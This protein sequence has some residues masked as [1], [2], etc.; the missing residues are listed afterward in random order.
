[1]EI[2]ARYQ[3]TDGTGGWPFLIAGL[4]IITPTGTNP[5]GLPRDATGVATKTGTG[6]G[7]WGVG[8]SLT[9]LLPS[10][11]ATLFASLG[12]TYNIGRNVH[13]RINNALIDRVEP[14]GA[15][16]ATVGIGIALNQRAS[17]SFAYAHSWQFAT[18]STIRPIMRD[19]NG[20]ET[21]GDAFTSK[22]RDLQIGRFLFGISYRVN[23]R[24]TISWTVEMGAT[25]DAN[26]LRTSLR[27]PFTLN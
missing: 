22:S 23:A 24:T 3:L 9:V 26:D 13:T 15:P 1:M 11:P 6:S 2:T 8:P 7:F 21:I 12:Y 16:S 19:T 20:V 18:R 27:I 10:D 5:F 17:V 14:G 25:D 4:Q